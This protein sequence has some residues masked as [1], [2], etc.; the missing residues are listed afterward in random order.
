MM[1]I[2][3]GLPGPQQSGRVFASSFSESPAGVLAYPKGA[4]VGPLF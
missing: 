4:F 1:A 3:P 2:E